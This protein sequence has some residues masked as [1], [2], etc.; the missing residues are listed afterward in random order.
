[1]EKFD[2][3]AIIMRHDLP[4]SDYVV[5]DSNYP[6]IVNLFEPSDCI[7]TLIHESYLL[8]VAH[9]AADLHRGQFLKVNGISHAIA[10][11]IIH[12]KAQKTR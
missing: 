2:A 8:A 1:M 3:R 11:V 5:A 7:G 6:A 12:P 10:E 9:C 4:D